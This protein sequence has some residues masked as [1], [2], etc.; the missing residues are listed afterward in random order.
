M[1]LCDLGET[2]RPQ[3]TANDHNPLAKWKIA[4]IIPTI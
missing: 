3:L 4:E 2:V 1:I